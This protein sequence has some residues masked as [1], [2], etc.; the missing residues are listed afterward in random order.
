[1]RAMY[2][3]HLR[4]SRSWRHFVFLF[5]KGPGW[6]PPLGRPAPRT[7]GRGGRRIPRPPPTPLLLT[8]L[9]SR[10]PQ[11]A[12]NGPFQ[13]QPRYNCRRS[14]WPYCVCVRSAYIVVSGGQSTPAK[15]LSDHRI[16]ST[17][18]IDTKESSAT[19]RRCSFRCMYP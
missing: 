11:C 7:P 9:A 16:Y 8:G 4:E 2:A 10:T 18:H 13:G 5:F 17:V 3:S 19:C 1:M 15:R 12:H 6:I 14:A